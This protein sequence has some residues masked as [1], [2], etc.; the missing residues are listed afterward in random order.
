MC[1]NIRGEK[2]PTLDC[3]IL[4]HHLA[5]HTY[6]LPQSCKISSTVFGRKSP[7][8]YKSSVDLKVGNGDVTKASS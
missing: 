1:F 4:S 3:H 5:L 6:S 8:N 7:E 2:I